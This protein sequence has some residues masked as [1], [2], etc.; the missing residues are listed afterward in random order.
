MM[1]KGE[2]VTV[3]FLKNKSDKENILKEAERLKKKK[4][5]YIED[6]LKFDDWVKCMKE[7]GKIIREAKEDQYYDQPEWGYNY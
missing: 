6:W 2:G 1:Q 7:R 3:V 5:Y 4:E